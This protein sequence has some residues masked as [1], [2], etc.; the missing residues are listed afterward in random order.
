MAESSATTSVSSRPGQSYLHCLEM[1]PLSALP[2]L[3]EASRDLLRRSAELP[4]TEQGLLAVLAEYRYAVYTLVSIGE[5]LF[6]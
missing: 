2:A 1:P 3:V 4:D 5:G 6:D